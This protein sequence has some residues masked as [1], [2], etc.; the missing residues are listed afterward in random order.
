MRGLVS[1]A[2]GDE[3]PTGTFQPHLPRV[4]PHLPRENPTSTSRHPTSSCIWGGGENNWDLV[5]LTPSLRIWDEAKSLL[6]NAP[7]RAA[8]AARLTP[9]KVEVIFPNVLDSL[10][11]TWKKNLE[12][13]GPQG[14]WIFSLD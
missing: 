1:P 8:L 7:G 11:V 9:G 2:M 6:E 3:E 13:G 14:M 10:A 5:S 4:T 12:E